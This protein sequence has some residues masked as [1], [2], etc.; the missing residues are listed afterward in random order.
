VLFRVHAGIV[1]IIIGAEKIN[2]KIVKRKLFLQ[3]DAT[4]CRSWCGIFLKNMRN[5]AKANEIYGSYFAEPFPA[6]K[7]I[8]VGGLPR[9]INIEISMIALKD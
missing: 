9:D 1:L 3:E 5:Y 8:Q 4:S 7:T 6:Y 2:N